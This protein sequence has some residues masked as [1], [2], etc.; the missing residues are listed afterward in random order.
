MPMVIQKQDLVNQHA[1]NM[2]QKTYLKKIVVES[3]FLDNPNLTIL[4]NFS[5]GIFDGIQSELLKWG[6]DTSIAIFDIDDQERKDY[7]SMLIRISLIL[8][9][10]S[11]LINELIDL[12]RKYP[13][14]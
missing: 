9:T 3:P 8:P 12:F 6:P 13:S 11:P 5:N 1:N 10:S 14:K 7:L 2:G 4:N